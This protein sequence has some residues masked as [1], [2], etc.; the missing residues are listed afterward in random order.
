MVLDY[1][2]MAASI[3]LHP[4]YASA[5]PS[6]TGGNE[7]V[8]CICPSGTARVSFPSK[9]VPK[10]RNCQEIVIQLGVVRDLRVPHDRP[11]EH[12]SSDVSH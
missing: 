9:A 3:I 8:L 10:A 6:D 5:S 7:I 11:I 4:G 12:K 1:L 2:H